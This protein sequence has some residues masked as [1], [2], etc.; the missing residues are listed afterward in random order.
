VAERFDLELDR[1]IHA[2]SKGNRQKVGLVQAFMHSPELLVLDEPTSGLDPLVQQRFYELV[3]EETARGTSVFLSSHVLHEVQHAADR[4]ALMREGRLVLV[5]SVEAMRERAAA[6]VEV[7]FSEPPPAGAFAA[8]P[9]VRE[10]ERRNATVRLV[11]EGEAD[12]LVKALA[13]FHVR[14]LESREADLEDVFLTL[15][16]REEPDAG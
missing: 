13:G 5:D 2:L 11:V 14:R 7:T 10:V 8:I 4:V 6:R 3:R 16:G 12:G 1:P 9:G 15:Y